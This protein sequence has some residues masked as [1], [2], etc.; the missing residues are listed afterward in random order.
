MKFLITKFL[1]TNF[2]RTSFKSHTSFLQG[3]KVGA[4]RCEYV[5]DVHTSKASK[6]LYRVLLHLWY[7]NVETT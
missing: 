3:K 1:V 6:R 5:F 2:L 4:A 7:I